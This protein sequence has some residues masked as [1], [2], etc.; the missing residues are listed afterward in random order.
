MVARGRIS[1]A[2]ISNSCVATCNLFVPGTCGSGIHVNHVKKIG[3]WSLNEEFDALIAYFGLSMV[4]H[5]FTATFL[6]IFS[7][8]RHR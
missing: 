4:F 6:V 7:H 3:I 8:F 2:F 1:I 5:N